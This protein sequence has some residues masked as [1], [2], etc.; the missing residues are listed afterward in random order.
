MAKRY[1]SEKRVLK[2][3]GIPD[4]RHVTKDHVISLASMLPQMDPEVAKAAL[5]QFPEFASSSLAALGDFKEELFRVFDS[6]DDSMKSVLD[7]Y[8]RL[9]TNL[10][11]ICSRDDLTFDQQME[12]ARMMNQVAEEVSKKDT[13]NKWFLFKNAL[14]ALGAIAGTIA[15]FAVVLGGNTQIADDDSTDDDISDS[16]DYDEI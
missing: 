7:M 9:M 8:N 2:K 15:T 3:L 10:E 1:L 4:F 5:A 11:K 6:N 14:L 16:D 13:E 12:I